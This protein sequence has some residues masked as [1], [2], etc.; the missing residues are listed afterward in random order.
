MRDYAER[1]CKIPEMSRALT[2]RNWLRPLG[3][4]KTQGCQKAMPFDRPLDGP[5]VGRPGLGFCV[6]P[7]N[8]DRNPLPDLALVL[9][10]DALAERFQ[11]FQE[12]NQSQPVPIVGAPTFVSWRCSRRFGRRARGVLRSCR[13][14]I[15]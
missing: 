15:V 9:K 13:A 11:F 5:G 12:S 14:L 7:L 6:E 1:G 4:R 8:V 2:G 10:L 3:L